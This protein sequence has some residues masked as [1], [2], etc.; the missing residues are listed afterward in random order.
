MRSPSLRRGISPPLLLVKYT[1]LEGRLQSHL[2]PGRCRS[3]CRL[4]S[5]HTPLLNTNTPLLEPAAD[6]TSP[7]CMEEPQTVEHWLQRCPNLDVLRQR[8]SGSPSLPFGVLTTDPGKALAQK[9]STFE[10]R[11]DSIWLSSYLSYGF[12]PIHAVGGKLMTTR[13]RRDSTKT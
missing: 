9:N 8:T 10:R 5:G 13:L 2:K 4:R 3:S 6:P 7:L 11:L 1:V 12:P